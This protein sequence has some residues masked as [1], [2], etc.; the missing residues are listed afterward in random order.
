M[1]WRIRVVHSTGY[2]YSGPV[3]QSYNE[4]RLTPRGDNR[5]NVIVTRVETVP[6]TRAY[7][8]TDYWGTVVTAFDLHAPHTELEVVS[9]SV[10]ETGDT[11]PMNRDAG[12]DDVLS[13]KIADRHTEMLEF[14]NYVPANRGLAKV[15][16]TMRRNL[17]PADAALAACR[18]VHENLRYQPGSTGVHTSAVEAWEAGEGVCQDYVH[19]SLVLLR[20]LGIPA[21]YVSG[22][23]IPKADTEVKQTVRGESHA[24]VEIWTGGW[25]GYDPT[26]DIPIGNRHVLVA[27][28]RDYADVS[29]MKGVYTGGEAE[30]LE[31]TVDMTRLA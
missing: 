31:V 5:Q 4:V 7:R 27:M 22:Y 23:L 14:S 28:G 18:W 1:G 3:T 2:R 19:L 15:A 13:D 17:K 26:N 25:W 20:Q 8:F 6:A 24:W 29:P 30:A 16:A 12:W 10:V 21:R 9:T 11:A